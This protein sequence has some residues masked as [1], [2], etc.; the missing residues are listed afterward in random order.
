MNFLKLLADAIKGRGR[1]TAPAPASAAGSVA[2]AKDVVNGSASAQPPSFPSKDSFLKRIVG[3]GVPVSEIVDVGVREG[4]YELAVNFPAL[5]HHLFEPARHWVDDIAS[6]Y[7]DIRH[8]LYA[9]ALGSSNELRYLVSSSLKNDGVPTHSAI[10]N[11]QPRVDGRAIVA[12][13]EFRIER[14]D[15]LKIDVAPDFLLKVDVDG[16]DTEVLKGFGDHLR[17][18]SVVIVEAATGFVAERAAL[19]QA[20]GFA[21]VDVVDLT[22]YG[23]SLY[24]LDLC[25][26]RDELVT[27]KLRPDISRFD[28]ALWHQIA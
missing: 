20:A 24:Q 15:S 26:V 10:V 13:E 14:F 17:R 4:T 9:K 6:N 12:V 16:L 22:Y 5:R 25:F 28:G 11:E 7:R 2:A 1:V 18:A 23:P 8:V 3:A 19:L 27:E 21:L